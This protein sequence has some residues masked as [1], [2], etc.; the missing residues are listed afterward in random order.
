LTLGALVFLFP[1]AV[2]AASQYPECD[3]V[4]SDC[5][6][7]SQCSC[8][9]GATPKC[10]FYTTTCE[11]E[12]QCYYETCTSYCC[13]AVYGYCY[14]YCDS[15]SGFWGGCT[16]YM[17]KSGSSCAC[18]NPNPYACDDWTD[19]ECDPSTCCQTRTCNSPAYNWQ[20]G[21]C[22]GGTCGQDDCPGSGGSETASCTVS[23][24]PSASAL[25]VGSTITVSPQIVPAN[26]SVSRVDYALSNANAAVDPSSNPTS[27]YRTDVTGLLTGSSTVT[28]SVF[29]GGS[30]PVCADS[31]EI[32]VIPTA[33]W[34]QTRDADV[35]AN[36]GLASL[37]PFG[38]ALPACDPAFG[39]DGD[40]GYPGIPGFVGSL[41]VGTAGGVSST[42]WAAESAS[43]ARRKYSYAFFARQI[44]SDVEFT[45]IASGSVDGGL[46]ESG[47]ILSRGAFWYRYDG[48]SGIDLTVSGDADLGSRRVVLLVNG[49]DLYLN[50]RINLTKGKGLFVAIVGRDGDGNGGNVIVG[51]A[52]G[53]SADGVPELEGLFVADSE[54]RTGEG[55][56]QLHVRGSVAG[57]SGVVLGRDLDDDSR[58]PAEYFEYAPD[59]VMN[60]PS[61]LRSSRYGWREVAP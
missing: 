13:G 60:V 4:K 25:N 2:N 39:L 61:A 58:T 23:L 18:T 5:T 33:A 42:G 12:G 32:T 50:G 26:G 16:K 21:S 6:S 40:G 47:G 9:G 46:F 52:V 37:I 28:A 10:N 48:S 55:D 44:P 15:C 35:T 49:A 59:L 7:S 24:D 53:G 56:T 11:Y 17:T 51:P 14:K 43:N 30:S 54:F 27:P 3:D 34:W 41:N 31:S 38:C 22:A 36:G 57:L 8:G 29:M 19:W 45:E 20:I 1:G